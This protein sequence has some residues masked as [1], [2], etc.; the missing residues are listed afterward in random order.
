[1]RAKEE[2]KPEAFARVQLLLEVNCP[3]VWGEDCP[4]SQVYRQAKD[5]AVQRV[6]KLLAEQRDV[7]LIG[8]VSIK[9]VI[10]TKE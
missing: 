7:R 6:N 1:M 5:E 8:P 4:L 2:E 9:A 10:T 3:G